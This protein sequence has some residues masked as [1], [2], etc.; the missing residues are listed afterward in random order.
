MNA[1]TVVV[2]AIL[3]M[4]VCLAVRAIL[5]GRKSGGTCGGCRFRGSC[6]GCGAGCEDKD[7]QSRS[8]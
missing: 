1:P 6:G 3:I 4:L 5:K 2:A 7:C 8:E